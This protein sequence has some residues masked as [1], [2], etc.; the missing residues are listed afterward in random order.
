[1][2]C[3]SRNPVDLVL[4]SGHVS[5]AVFCAG[6]GHLG[7]AGTYWVSGAATSLLIPL[8]LTLCWWCVSQSTQTPLDH[9]SFLIFPCTVSLLPIPCDLRS[10]LRHPRPMS[11]VTRWTCVS[12]SAFVLTSSRHGSDPHHLHLILT[13]PPTFCLTPHLHTHSF[14]QISVHPSNEVC[15]HRTSPRQK[16]CFPLCAASKSSSRFS[17]PVKHSRSCLFTLLPPLLDRNVLYPKCLKIPFP[18]MGIC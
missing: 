14:C 7:L 12:P 11:L 16:Q 9:N 10:S 3:L 2:S 6:K 13:S 4:K 15:S 1:M 8:C 18:S 5:E 17:C